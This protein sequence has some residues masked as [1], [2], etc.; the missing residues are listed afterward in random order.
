MPEE[1]Q[2]GWACWPEEKEKEKGPAWNKKNPAGKK[3]REK[4]MEK[5][6]ENHAT[7]F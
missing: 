2:V 3:E 1:A 6:S 7:N 4:G 5:T